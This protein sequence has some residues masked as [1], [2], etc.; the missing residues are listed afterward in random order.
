MGETLCPYWWID[1]IVTTGQQRNLAHLYIGP[2]VRECRQGFNLQCGVGLRSLINYLT[3]SFC[4]DTIDI[5]WDNFNDTILCKM[6]QYH[7]THLLL[8]SGFKKDF[9]QW[10]GLVRWPTSLTSTKSW[11][12]IVL[13]F[14]VG[15]GLQEEA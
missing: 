8:D 15:R 1:T 3:R 6:E 11:L 14:L 2:T 4:I 12:H 9:R 10:S 7:I 13:F 5:V